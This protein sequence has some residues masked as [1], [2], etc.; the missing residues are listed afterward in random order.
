LIVLFAAKV[1]A[2]S[3]LKWVACAVILSLIFAKVFSYISIHA[4]INTSINDSMQ[5]V[6]FNTIP[7]NIVG[8]LNSILVIFS[9]DFFGLKI[10]SLPTLVALLNFILLIYVSCSSYSFLKRIRHI[11]LEEL[12]F[13]KIWQSFFACAVVLVFISYAT[14]TLSD[15]TAT[16]RYFLMLVLLLVMLLTMKLGSTT[17]AFLR[18]VMV[19]ILIGASI[20]NLAYTEFGSGNKLRPGVVDN[21]ANYQN[22]LLIKAVI[23]K[24]YSK[25]YAN[26]WQG[27]INTYL[28]KGKVSF[29]PSLCAGSETEKF[30]WLIN[31]AAFKKP[32]PKT[33]YLEDPDIVAPATCDI[34][35]IVAQFG[36]PA[37]TEEVGD[38]TILFYNYDISSK[39]PNFVF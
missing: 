4:G 29:L 20:L 37:S 2:R 1:M 6:Q 21:R 34:S 26:Y 12:S 9:A 22:Y 32:A 13:D 35:Q 15:G 28:S 11:T 33:F 23:N 36:P 25:G 10:A 18:N 39:I 14:S 3:R 17:N 38:K 24:G 7:T 30:H 27:D 16:Y 19:I 5:F 31:N 8:S